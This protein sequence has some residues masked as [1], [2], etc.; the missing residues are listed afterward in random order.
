MPLFTNHIPYFWDFSNSFCNSFIDFYFG[1]VV[2]SSDM[3]KNDASHNGADMKL[4]IFFL[5]VIAKCLLFVMSY[6]KRVKKR[7]Q[8]LGSSH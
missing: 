4:E 5:Q 8:T 2:S 1:E 3:R 7:S 6:M